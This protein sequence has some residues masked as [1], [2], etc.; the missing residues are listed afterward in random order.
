MLK[1]KKRQKWQRLLMI[2]CF[3]PLL[4]AL[5]PIDFHITGIDGDLLINVQRRLTELYQSKPIASESA[6]DLQ[7]QIQ[8]AMSPFGYFKPTISLSPENQSIHINPGPQMLITEL[9]VKIEGEGSTNY[10]IKHVE[11]NLP[12]KVGQPLNNAQYEEAKEQLS[13]A[14]ENQGYLHASFKKAEILIDLHQYTTKIT[15]IFDT[16]PQYYFGQVHFDPTT[17]SPKLLHRYIPFNPGELY[18]SEQLSTFNSQLASSGYF[19]NVNVKPSI[20]RDHHVP[21]DVHLQPSNRISYSLGAGYGTDTGPRGLAGLHVIP[22]NRSGHKFN[23]I[24]QGSLEENALQ[25]QYLIPGFNPVVDSYSF[26]GG[27][28]NLDYNS[29][30]GTSVLLSIGQQHLLN[31]HQRILSINGLHDQYSYTGQSKLSE[32]LL[33]P[34]AVF[35]WN[36]TMDPLFSPTGYNITV[37]GL[38]ATKAILSQVNMAQV[39]LDAK[40]AIT[41]EP[42]RTRLYL[43]GIQG[44]TQINRVENIPLSLAQLLGGA[45]N[46]KGY[47][48]NSLGPGKL[49][50]YGG[51]EIQKETFNKWYLLGFIDSGAVYHPIPRAFKYDAGLG[52]M[53]VSP[54]GPIKVAIAQAVNN[55][56]SRIKDRSPKLVVN[57]G[58]DLS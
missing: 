32:S 56:F 51:L 57:M 53:W 23:A 46:L 38:A 22:V 19:K 26:S 54:V 25:A 34:K 35:S 9:R 20:E 44:A 2:L 41:L 30:L 12:I 47:N 52:L 5:Q 16:G 42:L 27:L 14:A 50:S 8:K 4:G 6:N 17:I 15:L 7:L 13:V 31:D 45:A 58:P 3:F 1:Q 43:H 33:F 21:I 10:K 18:S 49:I 24:A 28:T 40:A 29:G 37:N 55:D 36:K 48:F 11:Q 39:T